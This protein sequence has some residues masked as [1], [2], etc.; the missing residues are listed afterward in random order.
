MKETDAFLAVNRRVALGLKKRFP[1]LHSNTYTGGY[2]TLPVSLEWPKD[3]SGSECIFL[4][5]FSLSELPYR[6]EGWPDHGTLFLFLNSA[7][8]ESNEE[9]VK[10]PFLYFATKDQILE[11]RRPSHPISNKHYFWYTGDGQN[12]DIR[13]STPLELDALP[14]RSLEFVPFDDFNFPEPTK[15]SGKEDQVEGVLLTKAEHSAVNKLNCSPMQ[16]YDAVLDAAQENLKIAS[17]IRSDKSKGTFGSPPHYGGFELLDPDFKLRATFW[18]RSQVYERTRVSLHP[19]FEH[20][21]QSPTVVFYHASNV[22]FT[23]QFSSKRDNAIDELS[24]KISEEAQNWIDWAK[25]RKGEISLSSKE[26]KAYIDWCRST[27]K[28]CFEAARPGVFDQPRV[29]RSFLRVRKFLYSLIPKTTRKQREAARRV[30]YSRC[31]M[32]EGMY[33][34]LIKAHPETAE[35]ASSLPSVDEKD[36]SFGNGVVDQ[37]FGYGENIQ[38]EASRHRDKQLIVQSWGFENVEFRDGNF[39]LWLADQDLAPNAWQKVIVSNAIT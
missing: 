3:P 1:G 4:A 20:W 16:L 38:N 2:P 14:K 15:Y 29:W 7:L 21:P 17:G 25:I 27:Y 5:Q 11:E 9:P 12:S 31:G 37:L 26:R 19:L 8:E 28:L 18:G 22:A 32:I 39:K 10:T 36:L 23:G 24:L 6:P 33:E 35:Q 13:T 30:H 34:P